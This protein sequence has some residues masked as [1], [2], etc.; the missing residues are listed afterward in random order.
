MRINVPPFEQF[1]G[2]ATDQIKHQMERRAFLA[3]N[4]LRSSAL[5]VLR[6]TRS[7]RVYKVPGTHGKKLSKATREMLDEYGHKLRGG[8]L[9][10]AS[11][12]GEPP[13]ARTGIFRLSW[14]P[15]SRV[16]FGSYISRIESDTMT[17][18][19]KHNLGEI[20]QNGTERMAPRPFEE[21]IVEKAKPKIERIYNQPYF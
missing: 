1:V 6:G 21:P 14:Q 3:A 18:D 19:Y 17:E 9:Y 7:G 10:R 8:R 12:P 15:T 11:A 16:V 13:A 4:E 2:E 5:T 20:L